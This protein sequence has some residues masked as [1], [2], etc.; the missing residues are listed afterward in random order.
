MVRQTDWVS[1]KFNFDFPVG[2]LPGII[3]RLRG[4]P[5]RIASLLKGVPAGILTRRIN[6]RWSIQEEVGHLVEVETLWERRLDQFAAGE[7]ELAAADMSNRRTEEANYNEQPL[8]GILSQ[9]ERARGD[10]VSRLETLDEAAAGITALHPRLQISMRP[11][12]LAFFAAEHDDHHLARM[13]TIRNQ[14]P[15]ESP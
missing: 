14:P 3:E 2:M 11:V 7:S 10:L 13:R 12:D 8:L 5:L 9:F 6:D 4:T 15:P 1:R